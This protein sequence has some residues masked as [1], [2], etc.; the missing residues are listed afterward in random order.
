MESGFQQHEQHF[1]LSGNK[2]APLIAGYGVRIDT[3]PRSLFETGYPL[4]SARPFCAGIVNADATIFTSTGRV[5][6]T[7]RHD[8]AGRA[9]LRCYG[10]QFNQPRPSGTNAYATSAVPS[11]SQDNPG[12]R[13]CLVD[14][15]TLSLA[16]HF[17]AYLVNSTGATIH[18]QFHFVVH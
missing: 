15:T 10:T 3:V 2:I 7:V 17:R 11:T 1:V 12:L 8:N 13:T 6:F 4:I 14:A 16:D 9:G 18:A 5:G